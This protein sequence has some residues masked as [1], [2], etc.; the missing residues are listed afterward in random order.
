MEI[1]LL[2][3]AIISANKVSDN[4]SMMYHLSL[5]KACKRGLLGRGEGSV[6]LCDKS[7]DYDKRYEKSTYDDARGIL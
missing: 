2:Q 7:N 6:Y 3:T 1:T 4:L 5:R